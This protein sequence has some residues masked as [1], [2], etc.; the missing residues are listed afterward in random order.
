M[1]APTLD[2]ER[3]LGDTVPASRLPSGWN[4]RG[5]AGGNARG[6]EWNTAHASMTNA[7]RRYLGDG[8]DKAGEERDLPPEELDRLRSWAQEV[9]VSNLVEWLDGAGQTTVVDDQPTVLRVRDNTPALDGPRF[10]R[11]RVTQP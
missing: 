7:L 4:W 3:A 11:L 10:L 6:L 8:L 9:N 2:E 5:W 1:T